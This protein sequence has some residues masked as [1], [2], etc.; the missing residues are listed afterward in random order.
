MGC[1]GN[2]VSQTRPDLRRAS[3]GLSDISSEFGHFPPHKSTRHS[4]NP[5][6]RD[7]SRRPLPTKNRY[8]PRNIHRRHTVKT[9]PDPGKPRADHH[10]RKRAWPQTKEKKKKEK[11]TR[12]K[13][14]QDGAGPTAARAEPAGRKL[15][16]RWCVLIERRQSTILLM[17][18][19][20][21]EASRDP[22]GQ[23]PKIPIKSSEELS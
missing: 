7:E 18:M 6:P 21:E 22:P 19:L 14:L 1:K 23:Y 3:I 5:S 4:S 9:P 12:R 20:P 2:E 16:P 8:G 13:A 15:K 17:G 11:N 10:L